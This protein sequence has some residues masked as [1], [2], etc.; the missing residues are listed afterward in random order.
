MCKHYIR[1]G[2][3]KLSTALWRPLGT[4]F[5]LFFLDLSFLEKKE[6][7]ALAIVLDF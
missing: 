2:N 5:N 1:D 7:Y 4:L 3:V 6:K